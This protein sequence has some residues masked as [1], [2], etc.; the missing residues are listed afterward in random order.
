MTT[1]KLKS[2]FVSFLLHTDQNFSGGVNKILIRGYTPQ[3]PPPL[4]AHVCSKMF[5]YAV[6]VDNYFSEV[7][8]TLLYLV[9]GL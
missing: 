3:P 4:C 2:L 8:K 7:N 6:A 9:T 1:S 5:Y